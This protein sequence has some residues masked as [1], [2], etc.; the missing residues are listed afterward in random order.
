MVGLLLLT[1]F[2]IAPTPL[3]AVTKNAQVSNAVS[4][5]E[6]RFSLYGYTS[7][8]ALVTFEGVGIKDETFADDT[9]YFLF[10]NRFSPFSP[11]EACLTSQD[12][13]GRTSPP[14][15]LPSFPTTYN[16]SIGPVL[17]PSTLSVNKGAYYTGD[18]VILSGQA[19]PNSEINLI[20]HTNENKS[21]PSLIKEVAAYTLPNYTV[22]TDKKGN[23]S[24]AF[25]SSQAQSYRIF[26]QVNYAGSDSQSAPSPKSI[27][28]NLKV[29]PVWMIVFH[30]L[31]LLW[32]TLQGR[33]LETIIIVQVV[34]AALLGLKLFHPHRI[35]SIVVREKYELLVR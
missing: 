3:W 14:V 17:L 28:I 6:Y 15:C 29:L 4:V 16:V 1:I 10:T 7:P 2:F 19:I 22:T 23:F 5:G 35:K 26:T 11:R 12:Q 18:V 9:G 25:P 21:L 32:K 30:Y 13:F 8:R 33:L 27:T 20:V 31:T 24:I 34:L